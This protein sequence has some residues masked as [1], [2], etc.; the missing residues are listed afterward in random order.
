MSKLRPAA[1]GT[2]DPARRHGHLTPSAVPRLLWPSV[3]STDRTS[4]LAILSIFPKRSLVEHTGIGRWCR[5]QEHDRTRIVSFHWSH[6]RLRSRIRRIAYLCLIR[7]FD[8][9]GVD[10]LAPA[11]ESSSARGHTA[12]HKCGSKRESEEWRQTLEDYRNW[13]RA[14]SDRTQVYWSTRLDKDLF[15]YLHDRFAVVDGALWHFGSTVGGGH[16]GLTAASGPW[17]EDDTRGRIFFEECW[18]RLHA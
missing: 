6:S 11:M 8:E 2:I 10:A 9:V 14:G 17:P 7:T 18:R 13:D 3:S 15:P 1:V 5:R 12:A 16:R 4:D